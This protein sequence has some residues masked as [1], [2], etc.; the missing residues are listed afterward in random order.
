MFK[1]IYPAFRRFI[2]INTNHYTF[3]G[4]KGLM[5]L[6][7]SFIIIQLYSQPVNERIKGKEYV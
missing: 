7:L 5:I 1:R 4:S 6:G 3:Y 2:G